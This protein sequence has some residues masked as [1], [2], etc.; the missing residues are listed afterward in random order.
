M[1]EVCL[2]FGQLTSPISKCGRTEMAQIMEPDFGQTILLQKM[3]KTLGQAIRAHR[4]PVFRDKNRAVPLPCLLCSYTPQQGSGLRMQ[5]E[6][7]AA[8]LGFHGLGLDDARAAIC[9][10]SQHRVSPYI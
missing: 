3:T 10:I 5:R 2:H 6:H 1:S 7:P 9:V 4:S 8:C